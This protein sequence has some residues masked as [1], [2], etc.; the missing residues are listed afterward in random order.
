MGA[1]GGQEIYSEM[2]NQLISKKKGT[3]GQ[4]A[5]DLSVRGAQARCRE[6]VC[7]KSEKGEGAEKVRQRGK[8]E[9]LCLLGSV[10]PWPLWRLAPN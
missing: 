2:R 6:C 8:S 5:D 3:R 7:S 9:K 1:G 4:K 10:S